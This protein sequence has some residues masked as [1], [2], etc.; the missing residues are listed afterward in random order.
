M[1]NIRNQYI[2]GIFVIIPVTDILRSN[3]LARSE[4]C[5]KRDECH[6]IRKNISVMV[7]GRY[8]NRGRTMKIC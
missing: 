7:D 5:I 2:G 6:T 4:Q 1:D 3:R 8:T